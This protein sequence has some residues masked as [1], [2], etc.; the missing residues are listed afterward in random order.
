MSRQ[1][2]YLLFLGWGDLFVTLSGD[3]LMA[4]SRM[5]GPY[6]KVGLSRTTDNDSYWTA[7]VPGQI[8]GNAI[9]YDGGWNIGYQGGNGKLEKN[10]QG[11]RGQSVFLL[12]SDRKKYKLHYI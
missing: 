8:T 4:Q 9:W 11:V 12:G 7:P 5:S 3:A 2:F 10:V 1:K 6:E